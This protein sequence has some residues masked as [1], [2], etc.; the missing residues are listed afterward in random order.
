MISILF[1]SHNGAETLPRMLASF[2][3]QTYPGDMFEIVAVDNASTDDTRAILEQFQGRL[4]LTPVA[5]P[6]RGK[7]H[8]LNAGL[9]HVRGDLVVLTD[10]DIIAAPDWLAQIA[11]GADAFPDVDIFGGTIHPDWPFEPPKWILDTVPLG[12]TY[13]ITDD[14][15][16]EGE[17]PPDAVFG[18]NMMVRARVFEAGHRFNVE[19]GPAAGNYIMGSETEFV[20]RLHVAGHRCAHLPHAVVQHIVRPRQL[21]RD[22]LLNRSLRSGRAHY[23]FHNAHHRESFACIMGIP[24]WMWI[25]ALR[26]GAMAT[27]HSLLGRRAAAFPYLWRWYRFRGYLKQRLCDGKGHA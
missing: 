1:A 21:E 20:R 3:R 23:A 2:E 4:N 5:C 6:T 12:M 22:W 11:S 14:E 17:V 24:R 10:D 16:P 25:S 13:A 15:L 8:A 26:N 7:N 18:P 27:A 19:V 9:A